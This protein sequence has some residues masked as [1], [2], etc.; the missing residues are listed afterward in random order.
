MK[1]NRQDKSNQTSTHQQNKDIISE[2]MFNEKQKQKAS[3]MD[4][5]FADNAFP[6][7]S[8]SLS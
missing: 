5:K 8:M 4:I 7:F 1:Q 2:K 6:K 3:L